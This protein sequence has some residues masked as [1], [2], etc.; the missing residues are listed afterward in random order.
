MHVRH[1][2]M[3]WLQELLTSDSMSPLLLEGLYFYH[4]VG[5][6]I[7]KSPLPFDLFHKA[8]Q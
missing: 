7:H 2:F 8:G 4:A 1:I 6:K 3:W 5:T